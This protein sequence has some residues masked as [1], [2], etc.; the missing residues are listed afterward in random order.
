MLA[1]TERPVEKETKQKRL[2]LP[3]DYNSLSTQIRHSLFTYRTARFRAVC[4]IKNG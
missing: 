2:F 4:W 3:A 1:S